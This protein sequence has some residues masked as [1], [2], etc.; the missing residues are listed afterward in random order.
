MSIVP[1]IQLLVQ[2]AVSQLRGVRVHVCECQT[3][4]GVCQRVCVKGV[5]HISVVTLHTVHCI[6]HTTNQEAVSIATT[7]K[8]CAEALYWLQVSGVEVD[9]Q[10]NFLMEALGVQSGVEQPQAGLINSKLHLEI[11]HGYRFPNI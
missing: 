9:E 7:P 1:C 6:K 2:W 3:W 11:E 8:T 10:Y 5:C 4:H